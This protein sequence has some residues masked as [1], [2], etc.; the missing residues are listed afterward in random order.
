MNF[1]VLLSSALI[2]ATLSGTAQ[3]KNVTYAITGD[4]NNDFLW[5]NIRQVDISTGRITKTIF[6]RSQT[7]YEIFDA[8][9][10]RAAL[11][12]ANNNDNIG[13]REYPTASLVASAAYDK[14]NNKLFFTPMKMFELRWL[15]LNSANGQPKFYT[16]NPESYQLGDPNDEANHITRMVIGADGYGYALTNDANHLYRFSTGRN[17]TMTD[18]GNVVDA[19]T[20]GNFSIKSRCTSWG[21]DMIADAYGKLYVITANHH[22]YMIDPASRIATYKGS[23]TGLP[24]IFTTNGAAVNENGDVVLASANMFDGY[25]VMKMSDMKAVKIEGSDMQYNASDLANGNLLYQREADAEN[26]FVIKN[27]NLPAI[28][29]EGTAR[30]YPNP[31]TNGNFNIIFNNKNAGRYSVVVSDLT[32]RILQTNSMTLARGVQNANV[33]LNARLFKGMMMVQVLDEQK[34]SVLNEKIVVQ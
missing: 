20:N 18:L 13:A 10:S 3:D 29:S 16:L 1:K 23:I 34:Q 21:G 26:T 31:V 11:L 24:G 7:A 8:N 27:D 32:G 15:D 14:K 9:Q 30:V 4:G 17:V 2:A 25:Y 22:V 12:A 33:K 28:P 5:M 19:E 6:Q